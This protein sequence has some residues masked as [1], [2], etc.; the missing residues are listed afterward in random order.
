[1]VDLPDPPFSLPN[2]MTCAEPDCPCVACNNI[3]LF[4]FD[5]R[6]SGKIQQQELISF[7]WVAVLLCWFKLR[8][9]IL[10]R[11]WKPH[12]DGVRGRA[13][14]TDPVEQCSFPGGKA[15]EPCGKSP[16]PS[17]QGFRRC[18]GPLRTPCPKAAVCYGSTG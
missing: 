7:T 17:S 4:L 8:H 9:Q 10:L 2:T 3:V 1:M 14:L 12:A 18:Y 11:S 5:Y 15:P 13:G 6:Q 16:G